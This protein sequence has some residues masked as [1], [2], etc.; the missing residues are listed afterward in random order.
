[1]T[2]SLRTEVLCRLASLAVLA[3]VLLGVAGVRAW[4]LAVVVAYAALH[5]LDLGRRRAG[6]PARVSVSPLRVALP[7]IRVRRRADR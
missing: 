1:M 3:L 2:V 4:T 5:A 6:A 7:V